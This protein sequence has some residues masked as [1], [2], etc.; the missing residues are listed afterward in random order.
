MLEKFYHDFDHLIVLDV[1]TTGLDPQ[2]D[3]IIE[4]GGIC[5]RLSPNGPE[6][7]DELNMLIRLSEG[8]S[9]TPF[10]TGLTGISSELLAHHGLE[11]SAAGQRLAKLL[12]VSRPLV[13][14]Y[15]A[16]FD[17]CFLY[18]F[19]RRLDKSPLLQGIRMLDALTIYRDRR[20]YPHKLKDAIAAYGLSAENTHRAI[21][22]A[23]AALQLLGAMETE[24]DD[25]ARYI[26]L[27]GFNPRYGEPRPRIASITY[28]PQSFDRSRPL[29]LK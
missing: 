7:A 17:L 13:V 6:P 14:A 20:D 5:L 9:L 2:K 8:R 3:E 18:Y 16:Q 15:N 23:R 26:N 19:L 1:E 27:F 29:Y 10:I 24:Q 22:D 28:R 12:D 4:L 25:I 21:D 11:K